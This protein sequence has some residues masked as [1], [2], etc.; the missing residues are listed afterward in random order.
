MNHLRLPSTQ[1]GAVITMEATILMF[2]GVVMAVSF[3]IIMYD[4][5]LDFAPNITALLR[6]FFRFVGAAGGQ[7]GG[8]GG[9]GPADLVSGVV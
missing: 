4:A 1:Q 8:Q 6:R 5:L 2:V 7:G 3:G 9:G